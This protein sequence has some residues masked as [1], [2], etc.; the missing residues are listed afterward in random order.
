MWPQC[1]ALSVTFKCVYHH[2]QYQRVEIMCYYCNETNLASY[3]QIQF[4]YH[5]ICYCRLTFIKITSHWVTEVSFL[6][7]HRGRLGKNCNS[8][9]AEAI[10]FVK[11]VRNPSTCS[12]PMAHP[13]ILSDLYIALSD[14]G[15][16]WWKKKKKKKKGLPSLINSPPWQTEW[17][18]RLTC[19]M[20]RFDEPI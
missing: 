9:K 19:V 18:W 11:S 12:F 7:W 17:P 1:A 14:H 10:P 4:Y 6:S 20:V 3:F 13:D 8:E 2:P 15:M 16:A 5:L